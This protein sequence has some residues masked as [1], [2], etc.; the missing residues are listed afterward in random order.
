MIR[1]N[2]KL[3]LLIC[4]LLLN[5]PVVF[6]QPSVLVNQTKQQVLVDGMLNLEVQ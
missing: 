6:A 1:S 5:T 3:L 4:L 2:F